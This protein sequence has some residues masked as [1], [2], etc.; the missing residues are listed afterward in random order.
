MDAK[1]DT[2]Y[3][4]DFPLVD[5][6]QDFILHRVGSSKKLIFLIDVDNITFWGYLIKF[7]SKL[8]LSIPIQN[9]LPDMF[10]RFQIV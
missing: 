1:I 5:N 4:D 2:Y 9:D 3:H 10:S 8:R 6:K 7:K